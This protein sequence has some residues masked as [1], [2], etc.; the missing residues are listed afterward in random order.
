ME[1][2][3][4]VPTFMEKLAQGNNRLIAESEV[5]KNKSTLK[6]LTEAGLLSLALAT[7]SV[8]YAINNHT[9]N[10]LQG[11]DAFVTEIS[12]YNRD[13]RMLPDYR[14]F[15]ERTKPNNYY[16]IVVRP[17]I[18]LINKGIE[19]VADKEHTICYFKDTL[20]ADNGGKK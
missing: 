13:H 11:Y 5:D 3:M 19:L 17:S 18:K 14:T 6:K 7:G 4:N 1:S 8:A 2:E 9:Y 15:C 20:T 12:D 16:N 10:S